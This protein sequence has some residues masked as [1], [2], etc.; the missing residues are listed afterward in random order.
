[1][2]FPLPNLLGNFQ[3]SNVSTAIATVR[4]I[5]QFKMIFAETVN[6]HTIADKTPAVLLS[7]GLDSFLVANELK[8]KFNNL[9][10]FSIGFSNPTYDETALI[11]KL[12]LNFDKNIFLLKD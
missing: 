6:Q 9:K 2:N 12:D 10:S 7:G 11:K 4:N 1:M 8:K 5:D 3:I